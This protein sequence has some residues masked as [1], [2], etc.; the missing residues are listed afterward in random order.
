[1]QR[2]NGN[3]DIKCFMVPVGNSWDR[4]DCIYVR[5]ENVYFPVTISDK[6]GNKELPPLFYELYL[7]WFVKIFPRI[8]HPSGTAQTLTQGTSGHIYKAQFLQ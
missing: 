5:E 3:A 6:G 7:L 1:M 4:F 2:V 8:G